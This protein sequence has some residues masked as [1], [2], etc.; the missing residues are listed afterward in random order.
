MNIRNSWSICL[1]EDRERLRGS[2]SE[3]YIDA[4]PSNREYPQELGR[5]V[6]AQESDGQEDPDTAHLWKKNCL[7]FPASQLRL[8]IRDTDDSYIS[9]LARLWLATNLVPFGVFSLGSEPKQSRLHNG[10]SDG[11]LEYCGLGQLL[12][13]AQKWSLQLMLPGRSRNRAG[14]PM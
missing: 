11:G 12:S 8:Q 7:P 14:F 4:Y 5:Q 6:S 1:Q 2:L 9:P 3:S 13:A 10:I